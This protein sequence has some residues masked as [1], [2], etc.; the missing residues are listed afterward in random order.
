[1]A[2]KA[3]H[4]TILVICIGMTL[5][6][7]TQAGRAT[8]GAK[9]T[10]YRYLNSLPKSEPHHICL[11]GNHASSLMETLVLHEGHNLTDFEMKSTLQPDNKCTVQDYAVGNTLFLVANEIQDRCA[12][13]WK[14]HSSSCDVLVHAHK[15]ANCDQLW[16]F[17]MIS[18]QCEAPLVVLHSNHDLLSCYEA[19]ATESAKRYMNPLEGRCSEI[20]RSVHL[21]EDLDGT[22]AVRAVTS[23]LQQT[24]ELVRSRYAEHIGD[25][26]SKH[27]KG[28]KHGLRELL[29]KHKSGHGR[30]LM[31]EMMKHDQGLHHDAEALKVANQ[32]FAAKSQ[33]K[34]KPHS[35]AQIQPARMTEDGDESSE[36]GDQNSTVSTP[37]NADEQ[38]EGENTS[39]EGAEDESNNQNQTPLDEQL[40]EGT[41]EGP[42]L[43]EQPAGTEDQDQ[44][45]NQTVSDN[46]TV[47]TGGL[48]DQEPTANREN[49][50]SADESNNQT[51]ESA[52]QEDE[53]TNA[54][55]DAEEE[56]VTN[57]TPSG[58]SK[59][60]IIMDT[61]SGYV[62]LGVAAVLKTLKG[63]DI[64]NDDD[65]GEKP[66]VVVRNVVGRPK[67]PM[68][69]GGKDWERDTVQGGKYDGMSKSDFNP[70]REKNT[71]RGET[72]D[73]KGY[74]VGLY[75]GEAD[76][77]GDTRTYAQGSN[78]FQFDD[79]LRGVMELIKPM[80]F[81]IV[82]D[83]DNQRRVWDHGLSELCAKLERSEPLDFTEDY[84]IATEAPLNPIRAREEMVSWLFNDKKFKGVYVGSQAI[85]AM[86][87]YGQE[88]QGKSGIVVDIGDGTTHIVPIFEGY[89]LPHAIKRIDI[90][91]QDITT[92]LARILTE[93]EDN[94]GRRFV[95]TAEMEVVRKI[96][97]KMADVAQDDKAWLALSKNAYGK[98]ACDADA[99]ECD[100]TDANCDKPGE[101]GTCRAGNGHKLNTLQKYVLPD[102]ATVEVADQKW[103][104]YEPIF[105]PMLIGMETP[106]I[107]SHIH[108]CIKECDLDIRPHMYGKVF[109][110]GGTCSA[111]GFGERLQWELTQIIEKEFRG[112]K[113]AIITDAINKPTVHVHI[114]SMGER[115][116][117]AVYLG[118]YKLPT[119]VGFQELFMKREH[120]GKWPHMIW[121]FADV[122]P[123]RHLLHN[124]KFRIWK[125]KG[126]GDKQMG[127][128]E[129]HKGPAE[130]E[131]KYLASPEV[132]AGDRPGQWLPESDSEEEFED[133]GGDEDETN[134]ED[135]EQDAED[136]GSSLLA[137]NATATTATAR[138]TG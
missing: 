76:A 83:T 89:A 124:D 85:L 9:T 47:E 115:I 17:R 87:G 59:N 14:A 4:V 64:Y 67:Y 30:E 122:N 119:L 116:R 138:T 103:R 13:R 43:D 75:K 72:Y 128:Q 55:G 114:P 6:S 50:E 132:Y 100:P 36:A 90:G 12:A 66:L 61:G 126:Q 93:R 123:N 32:V 69:F 15:G 79:G 95:S 39:N 86:I 80:K 77:P 35:L 46:Q 22:Q 129:F 111:S 74:V 57:P 8:S 97:E 105:D 5:L 53:E 42:Q 98:A 48:Q 31:L 118:A 82:L 137:G 62:K 112:L 107:H 28:H 96:K 11:T 81:G 7:E 16:K 44:S 71:N 101:D 84:I 130:F 37:S 121:N 29:Y 40:E 56:E 110:S 65:L 88:A 52:D 106:G 133:E 108:Q 127:I 26:V 20:Q 136:E 78:A 135:G 63:E 24:S 2:F 19:K 41:P 109:L 134:I 102:G 34:S 3:T 99:E 68:I 33:F 131:Q 113:D 73:A 104:M 49:E 54:N 21:E 38:N 58:G 23:A 51:V 91:G 125:N 25:H 18:N 70:Y 60:V 120:G 45:N 92:F 10:L 94:K 1:M 27:E 117:D